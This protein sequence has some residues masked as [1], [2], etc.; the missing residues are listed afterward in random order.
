MHLKEYG[1][2]SR[3]SGHGLAAGCCEHG[4]EQSDDTA[5]EEF[6]EQLRDRQTVGWCHETDSARRPSQIMSF[7]I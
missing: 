7:D 3:E 6:P 4:T 5:G 2:V 1:V